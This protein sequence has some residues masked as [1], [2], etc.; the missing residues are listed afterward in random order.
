MVS[1]GMAAATDH[2]ACALAPPGNPKR[3]KL[4]GGQQRWVQA[5]AD[6]ASPPKVDPGQRLVAAAE[7]LRSSAVSVEDQARLFLAALGK[8]QPE[9][10]AAVR[11]AVA[12]SNQPAA[13]EATG[14][15]DGLSPP[16]AP[17][18]PRPLPALGPC[19]ASVAPRP[20][21]GRRSGQTV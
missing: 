5:G 18:R 16:S 15:I 19:P 20:R 13:A 7:A 14:G 9:A 1:L 17:A 12:R 6:A 3:S 21:P 10:Q 11:E 4:A 2:H 8:L